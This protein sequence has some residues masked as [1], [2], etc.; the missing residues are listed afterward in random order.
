MGSPFPHPPALG[1][2]VNPLRGA[3]QVVANNGGFAFPPGRRGS[4][5]FPP[6]MTPGTLYVVSTGIN[7]G[8]H[9]WP[10]TLAAPF[11]LMTINYTLPADP[12]APVTDGETLSPPQNFFHDLATIPESQIAAHRTVV[13]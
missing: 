12:T 10:G 3:P 4:F 9:T 13:F 6:R 7:D 2:D 5:T 8:T 1:E 11:I